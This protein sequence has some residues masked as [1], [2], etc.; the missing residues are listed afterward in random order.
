M[1]LLTAPIPPQ[2][3]TYTADDLLQMPDSVGYE[4]VD[5]QLRERNVSEESSG[6][7][8]TN[9]ILLGIEARRTNEAKIY[10]SDL[11]YNCFPPDAEKEI[12]KPDASLIRRE[13]LA[14]LKGR[15]GYMPIPADL[16]VEVLSPNDLI[17]DVNDKVEEYLAAGFG[18]V[19]VVDPKQKNVMVHRRDGSVTKVHENEEITGETALPGFRCRVGEFL[20]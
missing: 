5:G 7:A 16:V 2:T 20:K 11:G 19:W 8:A 15:V 3:R 4:L 12:R 14:A 17:R 6:V 1:T 9:V 18:L 13:R 10:G